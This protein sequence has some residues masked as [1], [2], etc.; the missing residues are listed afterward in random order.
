ME[1]KQGKIYKPLS[2]TLSLTGRVCDSIKDFILNGKYD[3]NQRLNEAELA[4][5]LGISRGPIREAIQSP[6][7]SISALSLKG[8]GLFLRPVR[9]T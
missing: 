1:N 3:Q 5:A 4:A 2:T 9:Q 6:R 7:F 8:D